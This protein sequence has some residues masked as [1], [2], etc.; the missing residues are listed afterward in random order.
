MNRQ[1]KILKF[2]YEKSYQWKWKV[3]VVMFIERERHDMTYNHHTGPM[4]RNSS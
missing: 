4:K 3:V 2:T 1:F